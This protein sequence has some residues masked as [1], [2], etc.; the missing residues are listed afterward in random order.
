[1]S[2][3]ALVLMDIMVTPLVLILLVTWRNRI[4]V[5]AIIHQYRNVKNQTIVKFY[6]KVVVNVLAL[7]VSLFSLCRFISLSNQF[8]EVL[9]SF[10]LV[11][12]I[13]FSVP[14]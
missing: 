11:I 2:T 3:A 1:M 12:E 5:N 6:E 9:S 7:F 10:V 8:L 14:D 13:I 4:I